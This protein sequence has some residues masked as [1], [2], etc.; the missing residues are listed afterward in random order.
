MRVLTYP[1]A[2]GGS[3]KHVSQRRKGRSVALLPALPLGLWG[4]WLPG[5]E[6]GF[7]GGAGGAAAQLSDMWEQK[8]CSIRSSL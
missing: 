4:P 3:S 6:A 5:W 2:S 8:D 1:Y 7:M